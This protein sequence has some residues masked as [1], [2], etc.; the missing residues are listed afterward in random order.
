MALM[1]TDIF[2]QTPPLLERLTT[3]TCS[4]LLQQTQEVLREASA[5]ADTTVASTE[6]A[7]QQCEALNWTGHSSELFR[8]Q[9]ISLRSQ[10]Q[11]FRVSGVL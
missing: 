3:C 10:L 2:F 7:L 6:S 9:C 8:Q 1:R 11:H 4:L 5:M